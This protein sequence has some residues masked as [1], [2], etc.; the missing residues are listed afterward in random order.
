MLYNITNSKLAWKVCSVW[1]VTPEL[2]ES[3]QNL[4]KTL[5]RTGVWH[6]VGTG[7]LSP[8]NGSNWCFWSQ[9]YRKFFFRECKRWVTYIPQL[10]WWDVWGPHFAPALDPDV[11]TNPAP[12]RQLIRLARQKMRRKLSLQIWTPNLKMSQTAILNKLCSLSHM[13][14]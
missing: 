1:P 10:N 6:A 11:P 3:L 14:Y 7:H 13:N 8:W 12:T 2:I 9:F 4:H 5:C